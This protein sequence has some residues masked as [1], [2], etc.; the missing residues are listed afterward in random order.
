[1]E[2]N[3]FKMVK[4]LG[5]KKCVDQGVVTY[6]AGANDAP[7][8]ADLP[9]STNLYGR[10]LTGGQPFAKLFDGELAERSNAAV[11]KTVDGVTRPGVR[12]PRSPP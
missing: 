4:M 1:M 6:A 7:N 5:R 8:D 3:L 11:L 10:C 12:I 9:F 2:V